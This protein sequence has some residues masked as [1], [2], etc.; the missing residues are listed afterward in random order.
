MEELQMHSL[1]LDLAEAVEEL[2]AH[3]FQEAEEAV[4]GAQSC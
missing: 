1:N 2:A 4:G 3:P